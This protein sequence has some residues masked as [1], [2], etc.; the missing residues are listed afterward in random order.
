MHQLGTHLKTTATIGGETTVLHDDAYSF[1]DQAFIPFET[2]TLDAGDTLTTE[3]TWNNTTSSTVTWGE[4]STTEMCFSIMY[5]YPKVSS[6]DP[7]AFC[8]N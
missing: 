7:F 1:N 3:C 5:R 8:E 4:S 2:I 6:A